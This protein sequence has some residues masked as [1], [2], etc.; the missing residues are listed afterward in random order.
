MSAVADIGK[1]VPLVDAHSF[2]QQELESARRF[3]MA[4][5]AVL[6]LQVRAG[7]DPASVNI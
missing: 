3:I 4:G 5:L 6:T 1:D 7:R 2:H